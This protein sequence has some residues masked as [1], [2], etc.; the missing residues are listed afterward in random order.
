MLRGE[1]VLWT[2][3]QIGR[4]RPHFFG[5]QPPKKFVGVAPA[6]SRMLR[7][8]FCRVHA[9]E[10]QSSHVQFIQTHMQERENRMAI[11]KAPVKPPKNET[12]QIRVE[13]GVRSKL[14][15]YAEFIDSSESYVVSEALKL[16]F[17]KD[18]EFKTWIEK[19]PQN[20]DQPQNGG[21]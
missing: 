8:P 15:R 10:Q 9:S 21:G 7:D 16:L 3:H 2:K 17:R 6:L 18:E 11:L 4:E 12:L 1:K 20:G 5:F 14:Q 13:E 19:L